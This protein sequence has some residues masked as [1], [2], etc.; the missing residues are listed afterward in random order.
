M[1]S[2]LFDRIFAK[3]LEG[4]SLGDDAS[5]R[6]QP[7]N[8]FDLLINS[9]DIILPEDS[10][11]Y[12]EGINDGSLAKLLSTLAISDP[13]KVAVGTIWPLSDFFHVP[14]IREVVDPIL[15][16]VRADSIYYPCI[17]FHCYHVNKVLLEW[18]DAF[19]DDPILI[20]SS[21]AELDVARFSE[22]LNVEYR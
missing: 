2:R 22:K 14:F 1:L 3:Q 15:S 21:I 17:H 12:F 5:W 10:V 7:T 6:L 11:L 13:P 16:L 8:D 20:S 19:C 18:H 9:L 4:I